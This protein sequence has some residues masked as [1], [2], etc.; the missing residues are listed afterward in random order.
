MPASPEKQQILSE[1][2]RKKVENSEADR[3]IVFEVVKEALGK[4]QKTP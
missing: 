1:T 4:S 3:D 2:P